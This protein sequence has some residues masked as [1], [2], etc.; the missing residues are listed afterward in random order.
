TGKKSGKVAFIRRAAALIRR[1][2]IQIVYGHHGRD[3][4]PT[5]LAARLAMTRQKIVLTRHMA[6]SPSSWAS[7]N[8]LLGQCDVMIAVSEFTAKVLR[9][10]ASEP[11]SPE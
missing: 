2:K 11:Q 9:E 7:R 8:F 6:K 4:W 3:L 1:E 5:I 10:G